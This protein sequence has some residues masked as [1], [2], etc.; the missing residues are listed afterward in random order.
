MGVVLTVDVDEDFADL[1]EHGTGDGV[2]VEAGG[3]A[4]GFEEAAGDDE[5]RFFLEWEVG[6]VGDFLAQVFGGDVK[7][8]GDASLGERLCG[9]CRWVVRRPR[10]ISRAP[11]TS[12]LP[13]PVCPVKQL[14]RG[15]ELDGDVLNDG[16]VLDVQFAKQVGS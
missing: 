15:I 2:A 5:F 3:G 9:A 6:G 14:R 10:R 13:A 1:F 8:A 12:D 11:I 4:A 16:E 7:H